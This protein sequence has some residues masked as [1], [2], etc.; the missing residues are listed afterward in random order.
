MMGKHMFQQVQLSISITILSLLVMATSAVAQDSDT[1]VEEGK[2]VTFTYDLKTGGEIIESNGVDNPVVYT[3]GGGM[4][5]PALESEMVGMTA[6]DKKTVAIDAADA[7]G[8]IKPEAVQEIP[9]DQIPEDA[10]VEGAT[11]QAQGYPG[12]IL[13]TEVKEDVVLLDFNHPLAGKDLV[14]DVTIIAV[15]DAP[16]VP[17]ELPA[18]DIPE[19]SVPAAE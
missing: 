11:L 18:I 10:R 19:A 7:Y 17:A 9:I 14:F 16:P 15:E 8:D 3:Q 4:I 12:P 2:Q 6:G 5:L 1:A 13:V